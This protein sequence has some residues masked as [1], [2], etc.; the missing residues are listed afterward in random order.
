M[1]TDRRRFGWA[2]AI[3][4]T[5]GV[6]YVLVYLYA[7]GDLSVSPVRAWSLSL[8]D[9]PLRQALASRAPLHFEG[10]GLAQLGAIVWL[11]SPLNIVIGT[12]IGV[13]LALNI[14]Y[15]LDDA[16]RGAA[17]A[18]AGPGRASAPAALGG[19]LPALLAGGSCCAPSLLLVLGIPGLGALG[20]FFGWLVP[21]SMALLLA[22]LIWQR[23]RLRK[24][25]YRRRPTRGR[26]FS[27]NY[28]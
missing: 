22:N 23:Q 6:V 26:G 11:I 12:T 9:I 3:A 8:G 15:L 27:G 21:A 10:V 13:L 1:A 24:G 17:C 20:G 14:R 19:A 16:S 18:L 2:T 7:L 25:A 28:E 5:A 4:T